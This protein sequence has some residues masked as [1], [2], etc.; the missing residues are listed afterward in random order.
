MNGMTVEQPEPVTGKR[1]P[2]LVR[3]AVSTDIE[4]IALF[5]LDYTTEY[6]WQ[7]DGAEGDRQQ[8]V[9]FRQ[10][11][12]PRQIRVLPQRDVKRVVRT[13]QDRRL[14]IVA[15]RGDRLMGYLAIDSSTL[16]DVGWIA[17]LGVDRMYRR[18]GVGSA[19]L[20]SAMQ[21]AAQV[22]V[23][24]L[25]AELQAKN[26]PGIGFFKQ[27]GFL[28]CGYNDLYYANQ[29]VALHFGRNL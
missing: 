14:F 17:D 6:V 11:R 1:P 3:K 16:E 2:L 9:N 12:L 21:W 19:L 4:K 8:T 28:F 20:T 13:W 24:R 26:Q 25:V 29:D 22:G 23:R 15:E 27:H 10:V 18:Q 7:M 5:E